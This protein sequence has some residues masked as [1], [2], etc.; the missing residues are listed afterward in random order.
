MAQ[1]ES[2]SSRGPVR[3]ATLPTT[4][5][6][7]LVAMLTMASSGSGAVT[8]GAEIPLA[9]PFVAKDSP[10]RP[11]ENRDPFWGERRVRNVSQP[12]LTPFLP[13]T[14]N[15][16]GTSMIVVPGGGFMFESVESEGSMVAEWLAERGITA[17]MLKYRTNPSDPDT[18]K[19]QDA[20]K[21]LFT[22][23]ITNAGRISDAPGA[24]EGSEDGLEAVR[25]VRA[26][27]KEFG[28]LPNRVGMI[29]F[30]AGGYVTLYAGTAPDA[31]SRPDFIAPIYGGM[32]NREIPAN[33]PPAFLAVAEDDPLL[34]T[35]SGPIALAWR[36][37]G[38]SA[39]LHEYASGGHGFGLLKKG[40]ASDHWPEAFANWLAARGLVGPGCQ[41]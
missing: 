18:G 1:S 5:I 2:E 33:P 28:L 29:G 22:T 26:H 30:S 32:P 15:A 14:P 16:C 11:P 23:K 38:G 19:F 7:A 24:I 10:V 8:P 39:E 9:T 40:K 25:W 37:K 6:G 12:A 35:A 20:L 41:P 4:L 27:A 31:A 13:A 17:F 36:A 21:A 3:A 34:A